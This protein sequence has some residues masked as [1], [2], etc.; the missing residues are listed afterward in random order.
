M[1]YNLLNA[2]KFRPDVELSREHFLLPEKCPNNIKLR[3][4]D[5]HRCCCESVGNNRQ[6]PLCIKQGAKNSSTPL[7]QKPLDFSY[8]H[9]YNDVYSA[10]RI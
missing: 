4:E 6:L 7:F 2:A 5:Q 8:P 10:L 9:Q 3:R 1:N